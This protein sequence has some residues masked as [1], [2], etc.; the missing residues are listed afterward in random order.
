MFRITFQKKYRI[1]KL[2]LNSIP[3]SEDYFVEKM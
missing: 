1:K 2:W 3:Y